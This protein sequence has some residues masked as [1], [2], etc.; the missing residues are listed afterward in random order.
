[1]HEY[2]IAQNM[3][4]AALEY[5]E[6]HRAKRILRL[7]IEMSGWADESQESLLFYF[8][9]VTPGTIAEG[10]EVSIQT[11][12]ALAKCQDCGSEFAFG[13]DTS[14]C[15]SCASPH[16]APVPHDEFRLVSVEGE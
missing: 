1:M 7:T 14:V 8:G 12:P 5:A 10:A 9:L 11:A 13:V 15:P 16:L 6:Q 2:G 4:K 3:L